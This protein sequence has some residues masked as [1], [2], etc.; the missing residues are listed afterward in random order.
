MASVVT[1]MDAA[2]AGAGDAASTEELLA[3][4]LDDATARRVSS[5]R[6]T[7]TGRF[8]R[9]GARAQYLGLPQVLPYL[10]LLVADDSAAVVRSGEGPFGRRGAVGDRER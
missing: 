1:E 5:G 3:R 8:A 7:A 2:A 4:V 9:F 10:V 6:G